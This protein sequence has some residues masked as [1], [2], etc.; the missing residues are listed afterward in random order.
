MGMSASQAR[1]LG[2]IA[3]QSNLEY[4][5]QQI[6]QERTVLSQQ[7]T[8]LYNSLLAMQVPTP[9]STSDYTTVQ[10]SGSDGA[11]NFTLGNIK[12]SADGNTYI[13]EKQTTQAGDALSQ[14][15]SSA[16]VTS[17]S[18]NLTGNLLDSSETTTMQPID[19]YEAKSNYEEGD[20]FLIQNP[21]VNADNFGDGEYYTLENGR[22]EKA[23]SYQEGK[24]YYRLNNPE[25]EF[26]QGVNVPV[27]QVSEPAYNT[28]SSIENLFVKTSSGNWRAATV[29][30]FTKVEGGYQ[31]KSGLEY[32]VRGQGS[33]VI[34]NPNPNSY[35]IAGN[36]AYTFEEAKNLPQYQDIGWGGYEQAILNTFGNNY[37]TS[38]FMV[39]FTTS[40]SG[41][42]VPHF[43][44]AQDVQGSDDRAVVYDYMA[45]GTY[46]FTESI[47]GCELTFDTSG[48]IT[49]MSQPVRDSQGNI[50]GY[51]EIPLEAATVT[52][53]LA[54]QDAYAQYEYAQYEYDKAQQEINAKTEIIQQEDRNLELKL[55][56]LDNERTQITTEIEAVSKVIDD[57]IEASYKT[58]SG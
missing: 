56:R 42:I 47:E 14:R 4:Q 26:I 50:T 8:A 36:T 35:T 13:V 46:T 7:S 25:E 44:L 58:F 31:Y 9:P 24:D 17:P 38:D 22:Y 41:S 16:I 5:G 45:N 49:S 48:R 51:T 55:Q 23:T 20:R 21:D 30:D 2:L 18:A 27:N 12:P 1:Y 52:D 6:N 39:Y 34:P 10:Y 53:E 29:D 37:D 28:I 54:Y 15:Y 3:R 43:A 57:N 11:T 33:D 32:F 19:A 40:E